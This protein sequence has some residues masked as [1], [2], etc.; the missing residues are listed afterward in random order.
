MLLTV[1][2]VSY[3]MCHFISLYVSPSHGIPVTCRIKELGGR[4]NSGVSG[5]SSRGVAAV[6]SLKEPIKQVAIGPSH[7]AVLTEAGTIGRFVFSVNTDALDLN[8]PDSNKGS[9]HLIIIPMLY[10]YTCIYI[11]EELYEITE[12]LFFCI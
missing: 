8:K 1:Y 10:K 11:F 12:L 6:A 2:Y 4:L 3:C 7:I 9:V 5:H